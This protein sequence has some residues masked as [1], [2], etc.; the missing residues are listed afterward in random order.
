MPDDHYAKREPKIVIENRRNNE[1]E[2][3][4]EKHDEAPTI[5]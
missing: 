3:S 4:K 5:I 1:E 2:F